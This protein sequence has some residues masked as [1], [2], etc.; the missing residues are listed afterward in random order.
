MKIDKN[1]IENFDNLSA[2]E[3]RNAI[4]NLEIKTDKG[5][6]NADEVARL[7]AALNKATGEASDYKK[8][9]R[10]QMSAEDKAKADRE[11][12]DKAKDDL[13]AELQRKQAVTEYTA[14]LIGLGI[15]ETEAKKTAE[16]MPN[17]L[18]DSFFST[19]TNFKGQI[20]RNI[21]AKITKDTP[22]PDG[23]NN[24]NQGIT[25]DDFNKMGYKERLE[26]KQNNP[27]EYENLKGGENNA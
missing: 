23:G 15:D 14:K 16:T 26:L 3:L 7:K 4:L 17:G 24:N 20:E 1:L 21:K 19:L 25:K 2:D 8:Q 9:L 22:R 13:I 5:E 11:A 6:S 18:D 10:E 12:A 27:T